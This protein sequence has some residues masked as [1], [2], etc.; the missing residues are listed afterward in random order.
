VT[1]LAEVPVFLNS[2]ASRLVQLADLIAYA[3]F[4]NFNGNDPALFDLIVNRC[5]ADQG[6]VHGLVH[7]A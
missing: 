3:T 2:R 4:R 1:N 7:Q 5:D 6:V